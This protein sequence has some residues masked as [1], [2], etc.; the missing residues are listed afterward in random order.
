MQP[1]GDGP[2]DPVGAPGDQGGAVG[3]PGQR[4]GGGGHGAES[5]PRA[6][7]DTGNPTSGTGPSGQDVGFPVSGR[8]R[9]SATIATVWTRPGVQPAAPPSVR[10]H[11]VPGRHDAGRADGSGGQLLVPVPEGLDDLGVTGG[12]LLDRHRV[13]SRPL[14][15]G[16]E[17]RE[18]GDPH[19][20]V[21]WQAPAILRGQRSAHLRGEDEAAAGHQ[22]R[23]HRPQQ[24]GP[25]AEA[26]QRLEQE[27]DVVRAGGSGG[28]MPTTNLPVPQ[29][30]SAKRAR[31]GHRHR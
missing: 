19:R 29:A 26:E 14:E 24:G 4:R 10:R 15:V 22:G 31:A 30:C 9:P 8:R 12:G 16:V 2:A 28:T 1:G 27:D 7:P 5:A 3:E 23:T 17:R 18:R 11:E 21:G 20:L 25:V 6:R 13:Q